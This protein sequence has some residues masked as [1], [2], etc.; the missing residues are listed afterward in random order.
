MKKNALNTFA[1]ALICST[2]L[3]ECAVGNALYDER[4]LYHLRIHRQR[5]ARVG[6]NEAKYRALQ[7]TKVFKCVNDHA[8]RVVLV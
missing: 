2:V 7:S 6:E 4:A 1:I 3:H 5:I 8:L